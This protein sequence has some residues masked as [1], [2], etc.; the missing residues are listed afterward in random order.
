[1]QKLAI[2]LA[3]ILAASSFAASQ[4]ARRTPQPTPTP[5]ATPAPGYSES[6]PLPRRERHT[7]RFPGIGTDV[8]APIARPTPTPVV[9]RTPAA[10][11]DEDTVRVETNL[12][13]IP[14]SVYDRAGLYIANLKQENFKIFEDGKE[15]TI[16]YFGSS[17]KPF[18]VILLIDTSPSTEYDIDEIRAGAIAFV[19]L[20]KPQ[21]SVMVI[22]FDGNPHVLTKPTNDRQKII[23]AINK[24]DF[25]SGTALYD[26]VDLSLRRWMNT[27]Q[28][29]KAIVL[30]TDGVDTQS[31]KARYDTTVDLAEESDTLIFPVYYD[32][33]SKQPANQPGG[34][35]NDEDDPRANRLPL[36]QSKAEYE[37]GKRYLEDLAR[38][39]G[40]RVFQPE[41]TP[42]GLKAA[43]EG[44]AEELRRQYNIGYTPTD[45]AKPGTRKQIRVRVD[46]P[47]LIVRARDSY[48]VG[49]AMS[50]PT[51]SPAPVKK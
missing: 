45:E 11:G 49:S 14:V 25:G 38:Y 29:R 37:L 24:A 18:T 50:Q 43:F 9:V 46:R 31:S 13:T 7:E 12:I 33:F 36:G 21:D 20:L 40:G 17:E 34:L 22:E 30:F 35:P 44:I 26:A 3:V 32:N 10:S 4:A 51:P 47:N 48:I 15:Q 1:M 39:T 41:K 27:I 23:K 16:E 19:D 2:L 28:G 8:R 6:T 42:G 5:A